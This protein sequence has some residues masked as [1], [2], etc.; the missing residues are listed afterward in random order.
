MKTTFN[1]LINKPLFRPLFLVIAFL[2]ITATLNMFWKTASRKS[3]KVGFEG[4][5]E[6]GKRR[7]KLVAAHFM[8]S[9]A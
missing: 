9:S 2:I 4:D 6:A 7:D 5:D 3:G 8:V 1:H